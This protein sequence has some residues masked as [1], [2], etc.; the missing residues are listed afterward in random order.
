MCGLF[1]S[2]NDILHG[3][4]EMGVWL[5]GKVFNI[6]KYWLSFFK[7]N[8]KVPNAF[9]RYVWWKL[10]LVYVLGEVVTIHFGKIFHHCYDH[11]KWVCPIFG[12]VLVSIPYYLVF[13]V[14]KWVMFYIKSK[15]LHWFYLVIL[16]QISIATESDFQAI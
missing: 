12:H 9:Q 5:L 1:Y 11:E 2:V 14:Y 6:P 8:V 4:P 13:K 3:E 10:L 16:C 15:Q 7:S